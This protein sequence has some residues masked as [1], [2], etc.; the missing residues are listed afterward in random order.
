[1][2]ILMIG[3]EFTQVAIKTEKAAGQLK[4]IRSEKINKLDEVYRRVEQEAY[5]AAFAEVLQEILGD[6]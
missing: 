4:W 3:P 6:E 2:K 1:M 5:D